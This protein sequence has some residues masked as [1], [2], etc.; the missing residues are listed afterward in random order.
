MKPI[1][2]LIQENPK[3]VMC[4]ALLAW[5][6]SG[7]ISESEA[8]E[9]WVNTG[10]ISHHFDRSKNFN[11][12]NVGVGVEYRITPEVSAMTGFHK[13]SIN[14]RTTY[15][16]V[17]YQPFSIGPVKIGASAGLMSGYPVI[18]NGGAFF[19][20]LPFATYEGKRF[21]VNVGLIPNIPSRHIDGAVVFQFKFRVL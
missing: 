6:V 14:L 9:L 18:K 8:G 1:S 15:A 3:A 2:Q 21:G 4:I 20:A 17:N 16:A 10:G 5:G 13:N 7:A 11:E 12:V 19:A